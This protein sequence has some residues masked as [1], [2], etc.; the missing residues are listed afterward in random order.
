VLVAR[1]VVAVKLRSP[2]RWIVNDGGAPRRNLTTVKR[3]EMHS[4]TEMLA[5]E[6]QLCVGGNRSLHVDTKDG[7]C[8]APPFPNWRCFKGVY[9]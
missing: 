1:A 7:F 9:L 3:R 4:L 6:A 5:D 2:Q 8:S